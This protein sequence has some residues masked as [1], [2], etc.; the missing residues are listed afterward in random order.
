MIEP[1][2]DAVPIRETT[3][4]DGWI[5]YWRNRYVG[6]STADIVPQKLRIGRRRLNKII[7]NGRYC[8]RRRRHAAVVEKSFCIK[9]PRH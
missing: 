5:Q 3:T 9:L 4:E 2:R 1:D 6:T 7:I 8:C